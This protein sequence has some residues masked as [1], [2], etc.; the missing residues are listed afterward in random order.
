LDYTDSQK[1]AINCL[2]Q[3]LQ[4]IACAG[5]GKTQVISERIVNILK[6]SSDIYPKNILAFTYTE[7]AAAELKSRVLR[8]CQERI[9]TVEGV[10]EMFIGTIHAWCLRTLQDQALE[11]QKFSVLDEIKLKLFVDRHFRDIGMME[12]SMSIYKDTQFFIQ[13]MSI[14]RESELTGSLPPELTTALAKYEAKLIERCYFD[15]TM[16]QS[17]LLKHLDDDSD[18]EEAL[19]NRLKFLIVDEYQDVNPIQEKIIRRLFD[20]GLNICVVGDD[21]QTIYEWRGSE[22]SNIIDFT[23]KYARE[24]DPVRSIKLEDN[25]RSSRAVI[26]TAKG[27]IKNNKQRLDKAMNAA[28]HQQY[29]RGDLLFEQFTTTADESDFIVR[30]IQNLRGSLFVD[31]K[32]NEERGLDYSDYAILIRRWANAE[33]I[34]KALRDADI[35]YVVGGVNQLF[36]QPEIQAALGIFH[37]LAEQIDADTLKYLWQEACRDQ[38]DNDRLNEAIS[39]L[40]MNSGLTSKYYEGFI[41]QKVYMTF[42][43][44]AGVRESIF[45]STPDSPIAGDTQGEIVFYNLGMFSQ[46]IDDFESIH[47]VSKPTSKLRNFLNF[48][49]YAAEDYYP[50]GWLSNSYKTPNAVQVMTVFQ[51][52][53]LEFPVV[54]VPWL[55]RNNFPIKRASGRTVWHFL[56]KGLIRAQHRY[57]RSIEAERRLL[58]VAIT[59]A[60]KFVFMS[61]GAKPRLY[62]RESQFGQEIRSSDYV[63]SSPTRDFCERKR[64]TPRPYDETG[65]IN[66]NFSVLKRFFECNYSFKFYCLYGFRN[67]LSSRM[68]Y[69]R[70]IHNALMEIHRRALHGDVITS[71]DIHDL[72]D[73][74]SSFPHALSDAVDDMKQRICK[75]IDMYVADNETEFSNIE[76]AEKDIEMDLGDGIMVQGRMDLI[77]RKNLDGTF[78]ITIVEYKS[79]ENAQAYNVTVGQ[80]ELYSL[81]YEALTGQ[82]A[83]F[84]EIFN[85]DENSRHRSELTEAAMEDMKHTVVEAAERIRGNQL[86]KCCGKAECICKFHGTP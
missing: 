68:G 84:L 54:F 14:I 62:G 8:L 86:D 12:L 56:E 11:Y 30:T 59:R 69:G 67:P 70:S 38:L 50:E 57:E 81:G 77:K 82:K 24:R 51:S 43:D 42:L 4:I 22:I 15:Y 34:T 3:N 28:G 27:L 75:S 25:F 64:L 79:T 44:N 65:I 10:A 17:R 33:E 31:R 16:I 61:R 32:D 13:M 39:I 36:R 49:H 76:Y 74:H 48:V 7:K 80:L 41:L 37:L 66:L 58:Y 78:E 60:K 63:F 9:G 1:A 85:V 52:K 73:K 23:S 5:S 46:V 35:P 21:D 29:E 2:D 45:P 18:F 19:A 20:L 71:E 72:V 26:E 83:D 53:G 47:F 55:N 40:R 6:S